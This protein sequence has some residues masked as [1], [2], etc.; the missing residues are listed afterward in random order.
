MRR[1]HLHLL[2]ALLL[3]F[4]QQLGAA[5]LSSH[6]ASQLAQQHDKAHSTAD[7]CELCSLFASLGHSLPVTA[8][9][10]A[11]VPTHFDYIESV[12]HSSESQ[13]LLVYQSRAPPLA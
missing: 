13:T 2:L 4:T 7:P 5:H 1:L 8:L 3:V 12:A 11:V 9:N 10:W 6:A